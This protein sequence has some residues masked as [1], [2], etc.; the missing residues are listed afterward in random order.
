MGVDCSVKRGRGFDLHLKQNFSCYF[1]LGQAAPTRYRIEIEVTGT[2]YSLSRIHCVG[3]L[4]EQ[5][6]LTMLCNC[7]VMFT[8]MST[9]HSVRFED[10]KSGG[11]DGGGAGGG[12]VMFM[13]AEDVATDEKLV[14]D[15][16]LSHPQQSSRNTDEPQRD[17]SS[18][19]D[20]VNMPVKR[21]L[22]AWSI[23]EHMDMP[24]LLQV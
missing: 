2:A 11:G 4:D 19:L 3:L 24:V 10:G 22:D 1:S 5:L 16:R 7:A 20:I 9:A 17:E 15:W 12:S 18:S 23:A 14:S 21:N 13:A 8:L 6:T